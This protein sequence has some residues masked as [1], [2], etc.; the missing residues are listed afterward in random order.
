MID[1]REHGGSFG[2]GGGGEY[3]AELP[4]PTMT[5]LYTVATSSTYT[6]LSVTGKGWL[7]HIA[8]S[9]PSTAYIEI[10]I[11][12]VR[13]AP[14]TQGQGFQMH[15]SYRTAINILSRFETSLVIK[16]NVPKIDAYYLLEG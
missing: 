15:Y 14:V 11:D 8:N 1:I 6:I 5:S 13:V 16:S 9:D 7:T 3:L 4:T 12:G 10:I 2:G